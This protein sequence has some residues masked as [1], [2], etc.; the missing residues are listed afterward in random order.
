MNILMSNER[1]KV[2]N[3]L[4]NKIIVLLVFCLDLN[5]MI[6]DIIC[7]SFTII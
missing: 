6:F 3:S 2:L 5:L 1:N 4:L 7:K